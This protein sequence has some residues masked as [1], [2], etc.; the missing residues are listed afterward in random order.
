MG[1]SAKK[2]GCPSG[3]HWPGRAKVCV[4]LCRHVKPACSLRSVLVLSDLYHHSLT[5]HLPDCS[6]TESDESGVTDEDQDLCIGGIGDSGPLNGS[7][8]R[9]RVS[10]EKHKPRVR[11]TGTKKAAW[12]GEAGV[13]AAST[14]YEAAMQDDNLD[15]QPILTV[16]AVFSG[17]GGVEEGLRKVLS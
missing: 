1:E 11:L 2:E 17:L 5:P 3:L 12:S 4:S 6:S 16:L 13:P 10:K 9:S 7:A 14:V 15:P 8:E